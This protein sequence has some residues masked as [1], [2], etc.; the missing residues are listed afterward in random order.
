MASGKFKSAALVVQCRLSSTR[1]P[2]KALKMLGS[3]ECVCWTLD[4]MKKVKASRY[5]LACDYDSK[6]ALEPLAK[7]CAWE[8][9]AGERDDVLDRFCSLI[10]KELSDCDLIVRATGDNPFLFWEAA[11]DSIKDFEEN[12]FDA[13]YFT[14]SGLPHGC[15]VELFKISSILKAQKLTDSPY[16]KEH[17]GPALY[18]H[19]EHFKCVFKEAPQKYRAPELRTTIDTFADFKRAERLLDFLGGDNESGPFSSEKILSALKNPFL[20]KT[21]LLVPSV[22]AGHGT[23]HL[24][25]ALSLAMKTGAFVYIPPEPS[26]KECD[27][28]L[29]EALQKGLKRFQIVDSLMGGWDLVALDLFRSTKEEIQAFSKIGPLCSI[30]D[31]GDFCQ[32]ADYLL[33]VIPSMPRNSLEP[34]ANLN[35]PALIDLPKNRRRAYPE[36]I[37]KALVCVSGET[38]KD[39]SSLAAKALKG[40]GLEVDEVTSEKPVQNLRERLAEYDLLLTHYG[41][42]AFEGLAAACAVLL[43]STSGLHKK[44]SE[45]YGFVCLDKK[46]L[47]AKKLEPYLNNPSLLENKKLKALFLS[48]EKGLESDDIQ[49]KDFPALL[50]E[51]SFGEKFSCPICGPQKDSCDKII[52]RTKR[53]SFR[54]CQKCGGLYLSF[55]TDSRVQYE[56]DYFGSEYK[57]QYGKSY[58]EDFDSIKAQGLR[59][60]KNIFSAAHFGQKASG[61]LLDIGCAYGPFLQ[62]AKESGFEPYGSD[63]S[64][65][66]L[67]YVKNQL[68]FSCV[69]SSFADFDAK[70]EFGFEAFDVVTMWYVIEHCR[71]LKNLLRKVNGLLKKGGVFAFSTPSGQG[72]SGRFNKQSFFEQSPRDHYTIWEPS[73]TAAILRLFGFKVVKMVSTG[74][75]PER[76]KLFKNISKKP[77]IFKALSLFCRMFALGDT[78]EVYCEK[79]EDAR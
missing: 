73:K 34:K 79:V 24:R 14:Y 67:D 62:A 65:S 25:R 2:Q 47:T 37:K 63:I 36:R 10:N 7:K 52:A 12:H 70:K 40:L 58:L 39:L 20:Q 3:K 72:V 44:L 23:G 59:R 18:L 74:I 45:K 77:F 56:A 48:N 68:G 15:G 57:A 51:L 19:P 30:D 11:Q 71:D 76:I 54:R 41:F 6:S 43:L 66:A 32:A 35:N 61:R 27:S 28:L 64:K 75:H 26:L 42:T 17:V 4:A 16:D 5:F 8:I 78:F 22:K 69:L 50:E 31:G 21:I 60:I 53:H 33:D 49:K 9:F 13:D 55:S 38:K 29:K 1:L 46:D